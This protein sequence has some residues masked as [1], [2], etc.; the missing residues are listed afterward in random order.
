MM[1]DKTEQFIKRQEALA[2]RRL[3]AVGFMMKN[4]IR[5]MI[6]IPSR[7]VII[8]TK[9]DR[10]T[11]KWKQVKTLGK[12]GSGRSEPGNPPHKDFGILRGSIAFEVDEKK[13]TVR[14]GTPLKYG[15]HLEL[16]TRHMAKRP[17]LRR[18]LAEKRAL[19]GRIIGKGE[20]S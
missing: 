19:I 3:N 10:K 20:M 5:E 12:R 15:R 17:Y 2:V 14:V 7:N 11:K 6:S 9:K 4:H 8:S 1:A 18:A 13:R 16:G